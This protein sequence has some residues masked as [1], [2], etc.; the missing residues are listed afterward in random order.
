MTTYSLH[1]FQ[2]LLIL[3]ICNSQILQKNLLQ[4]IPKK[5]KLI[6][7]SDGSFTRN[8]HGLTGYSTEIEISQKYNYIDNILARNIRIAWLKNQNCKILTFAQSIC[9]LKNTYTSYINIYKK[10]PIGTSFISSKTDIYKKIEEIYYGYCYYLEKK[11]NSK[12]P[13]WGRKYTIYYTQ[14]SYITIQEFF[15]PHI[16]SFF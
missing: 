9:I 11:F 7:I 3:P 6:L 15:S 10:K 4:T 14:D 16:I 12:Q 1:K 13:I 8:L 5:W 2:T